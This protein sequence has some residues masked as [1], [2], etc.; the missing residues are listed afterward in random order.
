MR[1]CLALL[2]LM[3]SLPL[4]AAQLNLELGDGT[5]RWDSA[6]LL[7]HPQAR[8]LDIAQDVAYKR[9]MHYR[10]VPLAVLLEGI[11]PCLLYTSD[12]ADEL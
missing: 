5:H 2:V 4:H 3:F 12:A 6:E 9:A 10:A 8:N 7:S 11:Q 1:R